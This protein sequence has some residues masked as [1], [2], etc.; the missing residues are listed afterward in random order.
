MKLKISNLGFAY[1]ASDPIISRASIEFEDSEFS[2][3]CGVTGSGKS[4]LLNCINGLAPHFTGGIKSGQITV[5]GKDVTQAKPHELAHLIGYVN[6]KPES[7]FVCLNVF[8]EIAYGMEQ[9]GFEAKEIIHRV[10]QFAELFELGQM[11]DAPLDELSGGQKQ[12]VA[13]AAALATGQK[14]LLL[15]EPTSALDN[16]SAVNLINLLRKVSIELSVTV[17][18]A[19]HRIE[20]LIEVVDSI[21]LVHTDGSITKGSVANQ[22]PR[23]ANAP[24]SVNL[25]QHFGLTPMPVGVEQTRKSFELSGQILS[26]PRRLE[27]QPSTI[28]FSWQQLSI[29]NS[30]RQLFSNLNLDVFHG[31]ILV[32]MGK[33]GS[34]KTS[35]L[36]K[37]YEDAQAAKK[38]VALVPQQASDLLAFESVAAELEL[39]D[40]DASAEAGTAAGIFYDLNGRINTAT[41]PHDLSAGQQLS[42]VLA[43]QLA[44]P[45]DLLMLD[46]P[47]RGLDYRG[48]SRLAENLGALARDK[49]ALIVAT[50]DAEFA[51]TV[52]TRVLILG[53]DMQE[54]FHKPQELFG[55]Q[56]SYATD[57]ARILQSDEALSF[58]DVIGK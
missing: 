18:I 4:T 36:W 10:E 3:I 11:L 19:E 42:L 35:L 6:Q 51:A 49:K 16:Q 13:I 7:A 54:I 40:A 34:G 39:A 55:F 22:L 15:D 14:I 33:N 27:P 21:V 46:E 5:A 32:V 43:L 38:S 52:A 29:S 8:D 2:L 28:N 24:A 26:I 1:S 48:K 50:N 56:Q 37:L 23:L 12:R 47:T 17:L 31:E 57:T 53:P 9:L 41:H 58:Q 45:A 30:S 44:K 20:R 25:A